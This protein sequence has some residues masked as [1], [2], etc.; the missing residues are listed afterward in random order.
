MYLKIIDFGL[1]VLIWI[2]Q[3]IIYPGFL[4]YERAALLEWHAQ[5]T[6]FIGLIVMPLMLGQLV[7]H[8]YWLLRDF[9]MMRLFAFIMIIALW[10]ITYFWAMPLHSAISEGENLGVILSSLVRM[11]WIRT[12]LWTLVFLISFVKHQKSL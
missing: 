4:Y 5:Y 9:S 8:A 12:V 7:L 2:V 3:L 10:L 1:V 11:N 6:H